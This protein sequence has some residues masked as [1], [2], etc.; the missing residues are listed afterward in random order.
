MSNEIVQYDDLE[1]LGR[2]L[3]ASNYFKGDVDKVS[4]A[5]VKVLAGREMGFGP[6][7]SM[8]GI[9]IIKGRPAVGANL[10]A[11]AVKSH[12]GYDYRVRKI[13]DDECSIEFFQDGQS[14]GVSEFTTQDAQRAGTQNM[15]KFPRNMLFARAISNGVKWFCPDVFMGNTVYTPDELGATVDAE[16]MVIEVQAQPDDGET[17]TTI[18]PENNAE[19]RQQTAFIDGVEGAFIEC[20]AVGMHH[21]SKG[22]SRIGF[23]AEGEK[24][25]RLHVWGREDLKEVVPQVGI[26]YTIDEMFSPDVE[27]GKKYPFFCKLYHDGAEFPTPTR[28]E[29][30]KEHRIKMADQLIKWANMRHV[31]FTMYSGDA[32]TDEWLAIMSEAIREA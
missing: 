8:T 20:V 31:G 12:P 14:L 9:H 7:A 4:Q 29:F 32:P 6:I 19:F 25:P 21:T 30:G 18:T 27:D 16:G 2:A 22:K 13:T 24:Y 5:I 23:W 26:V 3:V 1:K 15:G 11:A 10:M 28:C 17:L